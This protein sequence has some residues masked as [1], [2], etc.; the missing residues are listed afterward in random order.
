[1]RHVVYFA[2]GIS[3]KEVTAWLLNILL[4]MSSWICAFCLE[5]ILPRLAKCWKICMTL[6]ARLSSMQSLE[7]ISNKA[8]KY[9]LSLRGLWEGDLTGNVYCSMPINSEWLGVQ[10]YIYTYV[11]TCIS[12]DDQN[13]AI[14]NIFILINYFQEF[15]YPKKIYFRK[16][17]WTET[18]SSPNMFIFPV[19][20]HNLELKIK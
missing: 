10:N 7:P 19:Q 6:G 18:H 17:I 20:P 5:N 11:H 12:K 15:I 4:S 1:M 2:D 14:T 9:E 16:C 13:L 3:N 8:R